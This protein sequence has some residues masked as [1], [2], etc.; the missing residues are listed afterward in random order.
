MD[1]IEKTQKWSEKN[2]NSL[3]Q[4]MTPEEE[5]RRDEI[6]RDFY[7]TDP[8]VGPVRNIA[9]FEKMEG[10]LVRYPFGISTEIIAE[11]SEDAIVTTIV[12][13]QSQENTVISQY[14]S[15]GVNLDNCNFIHAPSD[16]Y[17]TRDYGPWYVVNGS[18]EVSIVNFEY[19]RPRPNDNDIPIE[20]AEFLDIP[21]YG[22]DL[23]TAGGNYMTDGMGIASSSDLVWSENSETPEQISQMVEDYL[24]IHTY[25]VIPDPNNT[26]IDHIDCWGKFLDVD[27]VMIR[28]V[29]SSHAQYDEIEATADYYANQLSSYGTPFEVYRVYTHQDQPYTNSLILNDKV[30]IPITGSSYDDDAIAS[31][32]EAMPGYEV[33]GF[34]GSWESTDALH[35]RAKGI[36]DREMLYIS[37]IPVSPNVSADT[38]YNITADFIPYSG[39][40]LSSNPQVHYKIN[41]GSFN[42][43]AMNYESGNS[44]NAVIPGQTLGT[45]VA[46]YISATDVNGN[47]SNHP[48]IGEPDPHIFSVGG[49]SINIDVEEINCSA[50]VGNTTT[51]QFEISNT[52]NESLEFDISYSST[53]RIDYSYSV[54]NSPSASSWNY[55]TYTESG[56]TNVTV[57]DEGLIGGIS[58]SYTW[59]TDNYSYEGSFHIQS[60]SGTQIP[61]ASGQNNGT[62]TINKDAFN[63]EQMNGTW[64]I[65]IEDSYGDGGHQATN[66]TLTITTLSAEEMWLTVN[67]ISGSINPFESETINVTCDGT[68]IPEGVYNGTVNITSNDWNNQSITIPVVFTVNE[69]TPTTIEIP[70]STGWNWFSVNIENDDMT[71]NTVLATVGANAEM[72]KNQNSFSMYY[73]GF[74]WYSGNGLDE[75]DV[76]SMFM[77]KT[78]ANSDIS[79]DGYPVDYLNSPIQLTIEWNWISYLPQVSNGI[80]EA[81]YSIQ[82]LGEFIKNQSSFANY[83]EEFG[84]YSGNGLNTMEPGD[85]YMLKMTS[86]TYLVY[87]SPPLTK[88]D[89]EEISELN[90]S[91]NPHQY[92]HN[93]AITAELAEGNQLAVF[94]VDEVRGVTEATYFPLTDSY[95]ANLMVYGNDGEDLTFRV[96]NTETKTEL[97]VLDHLI[98]EKDGIVGNDIEPVLFKGATELIP[99][100]FGLSQNYP[101]PFNPST[102]I[103]FSLPMIESRHAVVLQVY[104]LTGQLVETLVDAQMDAGY[105]SVT[106]NADN[107]SSGVYI[108]KLITGSFQ[109]TQKLLLLK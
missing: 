28:E 41:G 14:Q 53:G 66:I 51:S 5:L 49:P 29:A 86:S 61:I 4:W 54:P 75:I 40:A 55:N 39:A 24:G 48:F 65:W 98:F 10:I 35:C 6:G 12:S 90:W 88:A 69:E 100:E 50:L 83:Y 19:N 2:P 87:G 107:F 60:P 15:A 8:P 78:N 32:Q 108:A 68:E 92:E 79:F 20:I 25:H 95:T 94:V 97:D 77:I 89:I 38:D 85:G 26:Y 101:N 11:M 82:P 21:L 71:L 27:K 22:M 7:E 34:T 31:Y 104:N 80:N 106:W 18:N 45:E 43:I 109:S 17:W 102:V 70:L 1:L 23:V 47:S 59:S 73:D 67:P 84:W 58:V 64:K 46:Y 30:L 37:H 103:G 62:Y 96:Y 91:V 81:L 93:M 76:T 72:I 99:T 3:P 33:L 105:H 52:G 13:G 74:G 9:E 56:W 63:D 44:Y 42:T 57:S 36:A 16:S